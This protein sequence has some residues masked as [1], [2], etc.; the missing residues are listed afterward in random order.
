MNAPSLTPAAPREQK[1]ER[2]RAVRNALKLSGS[3]A[4]TLVLGVLVSNMLLSR[5]LGTDGFGSFRF[6]EDFAGL[7]FAFLTLGIDS[8]IYKSVSVRAKSI[9]DFFGGIFLLRLGLGAILIPTMWLTLKTY[10]PHHPQSE[11]IL[12]WLSATAFFLIAI[13]TTLAAIIQSQ[14]KVDEVSIVTMVGKLVWA[15]GLIGACILDSALRGTSDEHSYLWLFFIPGIISEIMKVPFLWKSACRHTQ[16]RFV[17]N[18]QATVATL[19]SSF[20]YFVNAVAIAIFGKLNV[21]FLAKVASKHEVGFYSAASKLSALTLIF[22][23]IL[24]PILFPLLSRAEARSAKDFN[25]LIRRI[26]EYVLVLTIPLA[27]ALSLG[28]NLWIRIVNGTE[29]APASLTFAIMALVMV[30]T[31]FNTLCAYTLLALNKKWEV[32][33]STF[34]GIIVNIAFNTLFLRFMIRL[35]DRDG[36]GSAACTIT[37][38]TTETFVTMVMLWLIGKRAFDR[39]NTTRIIKAAIAVTCTIALDRLLLHFWSWTRLAPDSTSFSEFWGPSFRLL[40]DAV[41][42]LGLAIAIGA[43]HPRE[44]EKFVR[45]VLDS[46]KG[47]K[48]TIADYPSNQV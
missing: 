29:Y 7:F 25:D 31:Y 22:I 13:N 24:G 10:Y 48:T 32:T 46:R 16:L 44:I 5:H 34:M 21:M 36:G 3:L 38:L 45:S 30:I 23:P 42:Y 6:A 11:Y 20:P 1:E 28:A 15:I 35:F 17:V 37:M 18:Y 9:S 14:G 8:H 41:F 2:L 39:Q 26:F 4:F 12:V 33:I 40:L 47:A 19:I 43:I 27:L